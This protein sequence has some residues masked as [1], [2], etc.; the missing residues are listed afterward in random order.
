MK[1]ESRIGILTARK[2]HRIRFYYWDRGYTVAALARTFEVPCYQIQQV[3]DGK[4]LPEQ[5][6]RYC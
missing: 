4:L 1:K 3:I 6:G 5:G 2:A